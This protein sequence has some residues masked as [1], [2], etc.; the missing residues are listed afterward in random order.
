MTLDSAA[1]TV[2]G[3]CME[4]KETE[5]V[6]IVTDASKQKIADAL[7]DVAMPHCRDILL[8]KMKP[9]GG[10]GA[11]PNEIVAK[12]MEKFDVILCPTEFSLT[13]TQARKKACAKGAR[14]ATLPGITEETFGRTI[15]IDY[16]QVLRDGR[17]FAAL[18]EQAKA[19]RVTTEGGTDISFSIEGRKPILDSGLIIHL[20]ENGNLPGGEIFIAPVEKT[21]NGTIVV[22]SLQKCKPKTKFTVKNGI[23]RDVVG[24]DA[25]K[26]LMWS[27]RNAK[28]IAEFG[29]GLNPRAALSGSTL[30][31]EK[32]L[33]TV[34]IAF[35]S[36]FT[37]GGKVKAEAHW[38]AVLLKPTVFFDE[39][40][41]ISDGEF[42]V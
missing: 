31:E 12:A 23:V 13:H 14:V 18:F 32:V 16:A 24:D 10:H 36:N 40:K 27:K 17:R 28:N 15:D 25:F 21:A 26:E 1:R 3:K 22:D 9:T 4:V 8:L 42:L 2:I 34:H 33:G 6:L 41:A 38:D 20:G 35:G 5:T 37:F 39:Q 30:E 7:F 19:I 11:E 29:I